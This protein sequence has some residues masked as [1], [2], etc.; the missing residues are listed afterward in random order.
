MIDPQEINKLSEFSSTL[1]H[2]LGQIES[3]YKEVAG[4]GSR[5]ISLASAV[6]KHNVA[7]EKLERARDEQKEALDDA[8]F[9]HAQMGK[10]VM[11]LTSTQCSDLQRDLVDLRSTTR[12]ELQNLQGALE[13]TFQES[14]ETLMTKISS[15]VTEFP[16]I[17]KDM[18][19]ADVL[20]VMNARLKSLEGKMMAQEMT[21]QALKKA[22][23]ADRQTQDKFDELTTK[24]VQLER[25][26]E[27]Q[28][29]RITKVEKNAE[30]LTGV[31][32]RIEKALRVMDQKIN[33]LATVGIGSGSASAR[34][35]GTAS[36]EPLSPVGENG[37]AIADIL[38]APLGDFAM[39]NFEVGRPKSGKAHE[40]PRVASL[41]KQIKE[42]KSPTHQL[43]I[44]PDTDTNTEG[45]QTSP[46][47]I[48]QGDVHNLEE[49]SMEGSMDS[50]V[51]IDEFVLERIEYLEN[52]L[53]EAV[54]SKVEAQSEN[55]R[56]LSN[57]VKAL[58]DTIK[59][60]ELTLDEVKN[61]P[62]A[63]EY[64]HAEQTD[65]AF[66][67]IIFE[68]RDIWEKVFEE[69]DKK[70]AKM[71]YVTKQM[72]AE[73]DD[74]HRRL[75]SFRHKVKNANELMENSM[76]E[77]K[78]EVL[79]KL[80]PLLDELREDSIE[81]GQ[82]EEEV[83]DTVERRP[84]GT[85]MAV[86]YT[87]TKLPEFLATA[88]K[89]TTAFLDEGIDKVALQSRLTAMEYAL[90]D[91]VGSS[92][93]HNL[94][95]ELRIALTLKADQK[96]LDSLNLKKVSCQEL[97]KFREHVA[98]EIDSMREML[99]KNASNASKMIQ[100]MS[101]NSGLDNDEL[102]NRFELLYT[103]F[104]DLQKGVASYVPRSEIEVALQALLDEVKAVRKSAVDRDSFNE[105]L[106]KKA[107]HMEVE[108]L[109][110]ILSGSIGD[111][112]SGKAAAM[113]KCLV[114]DKPV[115]PFGVADGP[116]SPSRSFNQVGYDKSE[117]RSGSPNKPS[118]SRPATS[119]PAYGRPQSSKST[120]TLRTNTE[121]NILRNSMESLPPVASAVSFCV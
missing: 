76:Q 14:L 27:N 9:A 22:L 41:K 114:C 66:R 46:V 90:S 115:N 58:Q 101:S 2:V 24:L 106:K 103:Q 100:S 96:A 95:D 112:S 74:I 85:P 4:G 37:D 3:K 73:P 68:T 83:R 77:N 80:S 32:S 54:L 56:R 61:R 53:K 26:Q 16:P 19:P 81:I 79:L 8:L 20:Q 7:I 48:P 109:L 55:E 21:N 6:E 35:S 70:V 116:D 108:R 49:G 5:V 50:R 75:T 33:A 64:N 12:K 94:E 98:D 92:S 23:T 78:E 89:K 43:S 104:Q 121:V 44:S 120:P 42:R 47:P 60:L 87:V 118:I 28:H 82:M 1:T 15:P 36:A 69:L 102:N 107:D 13:L 51:M 72:Q 52:T 31:Q 93:V 30:M 40:S 71:D 111:P 17:T 113:H 39:D 84:L 34:R 45:T 65:R 67:A 105:K 57:Q 99:V 117:E 11:D 25:T 38:S 59:E 86:S 119:G 91:K 97:Q 62:I 29:R 88:R 110:S 18:A 10:N 63:V